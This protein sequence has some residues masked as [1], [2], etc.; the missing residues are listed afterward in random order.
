MRRRHRR[1]GRRRGG[2]GTKVHLV[3]DG[4]GVP[5]AAA[6]TPGQAHASKSFEDLLGGVRLVEQGVGWLEECRA[7]ATR[8]DELA[9]NDLATVKLA[10]IQRYLRLLAA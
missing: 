8:F 7:M 10:M 4:R 9:V 3:C 5:L 2:F 6:V 1:P